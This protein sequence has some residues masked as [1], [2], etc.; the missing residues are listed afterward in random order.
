MILASEVNNRSWACASIV[1]RRL[2]PVAAC[3]LPFLLFFFFESCFFL[4]SFFF[5]DL[6][7]DP[8]D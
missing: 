6:R 1:S 8:F 5:E 7:L 4:L 3:R 2:P